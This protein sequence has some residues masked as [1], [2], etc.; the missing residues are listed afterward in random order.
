MNKFIA[1]AASALILGTALHANATDAPPTFLLEEVLNMDMAVAWDKERDLTLALGYDDIEEKNCTK[2]VLSIYSWFP[3]TDKK[4]QNVRMEV[5]FK[6]DENEGRVQTID[7]LFM[8]I[9]DKDLYLYQQ[10][11]YPD[12]ISELIRGNILVYIDETFSDGLFTVIDLTDLDITLSKVMSGC[13]NRGGEFEQF[14]PANIPP[15]TRL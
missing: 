10:W 14:T 1:V 8:H 9:E 6:V 5:G 13:L 12:F 2:L 11:A 15:K 7:G 3:L 4:E